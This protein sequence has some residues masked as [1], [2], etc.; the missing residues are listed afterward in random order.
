MKAVISNLVMTL[1]LDLGSNQWSSNQSSQL[2]K[3]YGG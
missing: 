1:E 2:Q 3:T